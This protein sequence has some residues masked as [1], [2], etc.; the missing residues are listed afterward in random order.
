MRKTKTLIP[1]HSIA[2]NLQD[3]GD[4]QSYCPAPGSCDGV[5]VPLCLFSGAKIDVN[6]QEE[7]VGEGTLTVS[8]E[9]I[10]LLIPDA[11]SLATTV[12][13]LLEAQFTSRENDPSQQELQEKALSWLAEKTQVPLEYRIIGEVIEIFDPKDEE[14]RVQEK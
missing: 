14:R 11:S 2:R 6:N 12:Y 4:T 7:S 5:C 3:P 8:M 9:N 10:V 1:I 13:G